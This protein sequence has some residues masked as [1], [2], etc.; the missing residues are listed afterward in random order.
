M[1]KRLKQLLAGCIVLFFGA[2]ITVFIVYRQHSDISDNILLKK[3]ADIAIDRVQQTSVRDGIK[4][5]TLDAASASLTDIQ[6]RAVFEKPSV[7]FFLKDGKT[8]SLTAKHGIVQTDSNSI[9]ANG[10]VMLKKED[11]QLETER[12]QYENDKRKFS[13]TAPVSI[14]GHDIHL[15]AD[16]M[17]YD[18]NTN[19]LFFKGNVKGVFSESFSL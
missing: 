3:A 15:S 1:K 14:S 5:W 9:E 10:S 11:Y 12:L 4:E 7:T 8:L 16:A 19:Q 6:K 17:S 2:I 13:V 18:L